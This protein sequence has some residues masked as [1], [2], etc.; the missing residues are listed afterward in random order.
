VKQREKDLLVRVYE[1]VGTMSG[2]QPK[3]PADINAISHNL[4]I[5]TDAASSL[6]RAISCLG[7]GDFQDCAEILDRAEEIL[8]SR[9]APSEPREE[10]T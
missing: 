8:E 3:N 7:F 10:K 5:S 1:C 9:P 2:L 4:K 6:H